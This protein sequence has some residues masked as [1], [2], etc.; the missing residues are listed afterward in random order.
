MGTVLVE[1][2]IFRT[3]RRGNGCEMKV[4]GTLGEIVGLQSDIHRFQTLEKGF[5]VVRQKG[6]VL[7]RPTELV[8]LLNNI[9]YQHFF[10]IGPIKGYQGD[11]NL[12]FFRFRSR[13]M[14][15]I[16]RQP[17]QSFKKCHKPSSKRPAT[18]AEDQLFSAGFILK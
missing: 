3:P 6:V 16:Q 2:G 4:G 15:N 7:L 13:L 11:G 14:I 5:R 17:Q 10:R 9:F 1:E 18:K 12:G 8:R